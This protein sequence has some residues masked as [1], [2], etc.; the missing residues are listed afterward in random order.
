MNFFLF[1]EFGKVLGKWSV[2]V[3]LAWELIFM[4]NFGC[5]QDQGYQVFIV[6]LVDFPGLVLTII[7]NALAIENLHTN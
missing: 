3:W 6:R 5:N 4:M 1:F 7:H 2:W